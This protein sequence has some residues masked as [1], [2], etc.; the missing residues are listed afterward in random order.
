MAIFQSIINRLRTHNHHQ[1]Q[2]A[3]ADPVCVRWW[4][5]LFVPS[6]VQK[7]AVCQIEISDENGSC[8]RITH[9]I[10]CFLSFVERT[11]KQKPPPSKMHS[12]L[13]KADLLLS[14]KTMLSVAQNN[15]AKCDCPQIISSALILWCQPLLV[16]ACCFG[17]TQQ[18]FSKRQMADILH[19]L[20]GQKTP[21]I[22]ADDLAK[23]WNLFELLHTLQRIDTEAF[24]SVVHDWRHATLVIKQSR[25][26]PAL[27]IQT[28]PPAAT[29][30][31]VKPE[32]PPCRFQPGDVMALCGSVS[33]NS[34]WPS[35]GW[36][37]PCYQC[38]APTST[39]FT[40]PSS[41][42]GPKLFLCRKCQTALKGQEP[43]HHLCVR[44]I[45]KTYDSTSWQL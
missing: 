37:F 42:D 44:T 3:K 7:C 40:V 26:A 38:F 6:A 16:V 2:A 28:Q 9:H 10:E 23:C 39:K 15:M 21:P 14:I 36:L 5:A 30:S 29:V 13:I 41:P 19:K 8:K 17:N 12:S 25:P 34:R 11:G 33:Q 24:Q 43:P 4:R 22:G 18:S 31:V 35:N 45:R 20:L 32:T 27:T 1:E